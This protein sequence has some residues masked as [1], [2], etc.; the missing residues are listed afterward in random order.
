M[1]TSSRVILCA[2]LVLLS[3]GA[4]HAAPWSLAKL[5]APSL[6]SSFWDSLVS[7]LWE[8]AGAELDPD[9]ATVAPT[10][11][12]VPAGGETEGGPELDPDGKP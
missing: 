2:L 1:R 6:L 3:A 4:V 8:K 12:P 7:A 11:T 10:P 9:G 5:E